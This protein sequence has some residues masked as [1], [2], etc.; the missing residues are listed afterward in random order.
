MEEKTAF[1]SFLKQ[2]VPD[3]AE[4]MLG[5]FETFHAKLTAINREINLIS[6]RMPEDDYWTVHYLDS[7]L[8]LQRISMEGKR[9]LDFGTGGGLPGIP[10]ALMEPSSE[11]TL[12]DSKLKKINVLKNMVKSLDLKNC[13][14]FASRIEEYIPKGKP[15]DI[16]VC[17]SV[18][19][20]SFYRTHLYR[21][22]VP[23]GRVLF[24]K[25]QNTDDLVDLPNGERFDISHPAVGTRVLVCYTKKDFVGTP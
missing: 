7:L 20:E 17:R 19:Y 8:P 18:R 16:I 15:F 12:L 24:Y 2:L 23:K 13:S 22:L 21:L 25:A 3:V 4:E 14:A 6:R 10:I 1:V 11:V 5:R 9:V